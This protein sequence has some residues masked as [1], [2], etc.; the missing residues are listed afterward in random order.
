MKPDEA[1]VPP[2]R[3]PALPPGPASGVPVPGVP[4]Q[5]PGP[6]PG[7]P[8]QAQGRASGGPTQAA[9]RTPRGSAQDPDHAPEDK[10]GDYEI[11]DQI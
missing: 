6:A 9:G 10:M 7:G 8:V 11:R 2:P 5:A 1:P 4:I 3:R